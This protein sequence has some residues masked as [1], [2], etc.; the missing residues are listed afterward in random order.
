MSK[1]GKKEKLNDYDKMLN[2]FLKK[3]DCVKIYREVRDGS[4]DV[5]GVITGISND[6]LQLA[7][8]HEFK[9]NGEV[10]F[11]QDHY[12]SIRCSKFEKT[13]KKILLA[14]NEI[15]DNKPVKTQLDLKSWESIFSDLKKHDIHV[16]VD[17]EDLEEA[18]FSIGAIG[19]ITKKS[20]EVHNYDAAGK[21]DKKPTLVKFKDVT[22]VRFNDAYSK[23]FRKYLKQPKASS[24]KSS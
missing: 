8:N 13:I 24:K 11:R 5:Y 3:K 17:C 20:V 10:V 9:F 4:E 19:E 18:I 16:I 6:F 12:E 1:K 2:K 21:L 14:E 7:E 22:I 15:T 23:T